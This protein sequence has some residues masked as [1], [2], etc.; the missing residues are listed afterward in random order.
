M[1]KGIELYSTDKRAEKKIISIN[2]ELKGLKLVFIN[3]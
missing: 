3:R 1:V 2:S